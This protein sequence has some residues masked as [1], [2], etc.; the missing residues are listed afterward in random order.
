M[1]DGTLAADYYSA[2]NRVEQQLEL[3]EDRMKEKP[4]LGQLI[5]LTDSLRNGSLNPAQTE[6]VRALRDG[7][8]LLEA[9]P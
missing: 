6:I 3:P 2:M 4:S 1:Y 8:G 5:A 9:V 7:L